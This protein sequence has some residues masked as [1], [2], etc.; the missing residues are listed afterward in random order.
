MRQSFQNR[1]Y[2]SLLTVCNVGVIL[3]T[4][5]LCFVNSVTG[6]SQSKCSGPNDARLSNIENCSIHEL[7]LLIA[8]K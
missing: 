8:D 3:S 6:R 5:K 1:G 4:N 2:S 7:N